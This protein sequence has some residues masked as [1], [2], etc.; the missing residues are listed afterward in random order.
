MTE[1]PVVY[2]VQLTGETKPT[3]R[4]VRTD[5]PAIATSGRV[6]VQIDGRWQ[7]VKVERVEHSTILA[8]ILTRP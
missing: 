2:P 5:G 6:Q 4:P 7:D 8:M 3:A 1:K